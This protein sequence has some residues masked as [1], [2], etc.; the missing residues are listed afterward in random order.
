MKFV[1][2]ISTLYKQLTTLLNYYKIH[3][4]LIKIKQ[5]NIFIYFFS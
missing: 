3:I 1:N 2:T 5:I 4:L